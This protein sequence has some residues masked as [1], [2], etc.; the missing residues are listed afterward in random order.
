MTDNMDKGDQ[1]CY[2]TIMEGSRSTSTSVVSCITNEYPRM[3]PSQKRLWYEIPAFSNIM[4]AGFR[5]GA[6]L[7]SEKWVG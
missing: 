6:E 2:K 7:G 4:V 5:H 3:E 1:R